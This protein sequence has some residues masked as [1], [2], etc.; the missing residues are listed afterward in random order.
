[1]PG[2]KSFQW[3]GKEFSIP[4]VP[5]LIWNH[6]QHYWIKVLNLCLTETASPSTQQVNVTSSK[7]TTAGGVQE[8]KFPCMDW[9]LVISHHRKGNTWGSSRGR[10]QKGENVVGDFMKMHKT[11]VCGNKSLPWGR[12]QTC[13]LQQ[14]TLYICFGQSARSSMAKTQVWRHAKKKG[15]LQMAHRKK[16]QWDLLC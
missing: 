6:L 2:T 11:T 13:P 4:I 8:N 10:E 16:D 12:K 9:S 7:D 14:S 15:K 3:Q 5:A 1:M